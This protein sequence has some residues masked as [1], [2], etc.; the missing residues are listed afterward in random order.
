MNRDTFSRSDVVAAYE[1]FGLQ[2][3][4]VFI[5]LDYLD[6]LR[7]RRVLDLGCG[8]GR[9]APYLA[10]YASEYLGIDFAKPMVEIARERFPHFRFEVGDAT[11]LGRHAAGSFDVVVFSFN[12]IDYV[13]HDDRLAALR[14]IRRVLS[15][16]GMFFFSSHNRRCASIERHPRLAL[17]WRPWRLATGIRDYM[18]ARRNHHANRRGQRETPG[19]AIVN[20][21]AHHFGL[22]TYYVDRGAQEQQLTEQGF[23]CEAV[24]ASGDGQ[25]LAP[26]DDDRRSAW[27]YYVARKAG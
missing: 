11:D 7:D 17:D 2:P 13:G 24:Y 18:V 3:P 15:P 26:D 10:T 5:L 6:E 21:S 16:G 27:L 4:E 20:D 14:E 9:T 19:Y 23:R 22:L 1:D 25:R 12:G 8:A